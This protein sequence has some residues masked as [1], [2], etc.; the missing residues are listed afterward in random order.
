MSDHRWQ[1]YTHQELFDWINQG[2]GPDSSTEPVRRWNALDR[3]LG[4]ID[5]DL[6]AALTT[7]MADWEGAAAENARE[8]LRPLGEWAAQ[9]REAAQVMRERAEQQASFVG[10]ARTDMPPP[11]PARCED[12]GS[13][14]TLLTHL[15]GGQTDH[16]VEEARQDAAEQRAFEVMR[17]YENSTKAN[18]TSLASFAPPPQVAV[19]SPPAV[20][21]ASGAGQQA[22]TISFTPALPPQ[23]GTGS[24]RPFAGSAGARS[25][26]SRNGLPGT[27]GGPPATGASTG[28]G[29]ASRSTARNQADS[30]PVDRAVTEEIGSPGG[31]FDEPRTLARPVI[32]GDAP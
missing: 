11:V 17:V 6:A 15:F 5:T 25:G 22:V 26:G 19:Q 14:V 30:A 10:K 3:A 16:E 1:G 7:A 8:G 32:G 13:A 2:P 18:T 9:A 31:F 4:D 23:A 12:P 20:A 28:G 27:R 21:G 24:P 29:A